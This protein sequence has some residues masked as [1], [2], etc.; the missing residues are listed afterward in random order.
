MSTG[1]AGTLHFISLLI[2][3]TMSLLHG[4]VKS[5]GLLGGRRHQSGAIPQSGGHSPPKGCPLVHSTSLFHLSRSQENEGYENYLYSAFMKCTI[6]SRCM[7]PLPSAALKYSEPFVFWNTGSC[8]SHVCEGLRQLEEAMENKRIISG[9]AI[10]SLCI[11]NPKSPSQ[12]RKVMF[13]LGSQWNSWQSSDTFPLLNLWIF[14]PVYKS[15]L[16]ECCHC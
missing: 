10:P 12:R 14:S 16:L 3:W 9:P 1:E 13:V 15:V 7:Q 5:S 2:P 4:V 11:C 6:T 8:C